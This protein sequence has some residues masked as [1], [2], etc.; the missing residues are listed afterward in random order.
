M[1]TAL[2]TTQVRC[3]VE[4]DLKAS[5]KVVLRNCGLSVSEAMRLFLYQVVENDGLPFEVKAPSAKT[6]RALEEARVI[7]QQ[8]NS[9]DD[10]VRSLDGEE[11]K[12]EHET[13]RSA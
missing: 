4:E 5:A 10:M 9:I 7:A 3:R 1:I 12:H 13:R 11:E 6:A 8:F 2:K